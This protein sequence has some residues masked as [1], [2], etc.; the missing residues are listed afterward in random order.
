ME[1]RRATPRTRTLRGGK[2]LFNN[3]HSSIDCRV[4]NL[5]PAGACLEVASVNGI[6]PVFELLMFGEAAP[7]WCERTWQT[8]NAMGVR[9]RVARTDDA[10]RRRQEHDRRLAAFETLQGIGRSIRDGR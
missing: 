9:F 6:P 1:E 2:I 3:K 5:S 4:R 8:A 7:Y 10:D